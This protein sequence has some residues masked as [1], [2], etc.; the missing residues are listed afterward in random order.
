[1]GGSSFSVNDWAAKSANLRGKSLHQTNTASRLSDDINPA[2]MKGGKRE[3]CDSDANPNSTAI[4]IGLDMTGSMRG[5]LSHIMQYGLGDLFK[6]IYDRKPVSDPQVLF[7]GIGDAMVNDPAPFQIGQFESECGRLIDDLQKFW[8]D[9]CSGGGN[10]MESYDLPYYFAGHLT[11]TD[12]M[13][14]RNQKGFI[15]TIGDE[16]PPKVLTKEIIKNVFGL[17]VEKDMPFK[18]VL[19][20]ACQSYIPFHIIM[21]EGS[22]PSNYGL[23]CVLNPWR[24]LLGENAIVCSDHKKLSEVIVSILEVKAGKNKTAVENSW[25][26]STALVV[27]DAIKNLPA[28]TDEGM[29][30]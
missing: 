27:R 26:A 8:V 17:D 1:M 15:F 12:C 3:S 19:R 5:I 6:E 7:C 18:D 28:N 16:P 9:G 21:S 20:T 25:D 30:F 2:Q 14:K 24:D 23:D 10:D 4:I 13:L 22:H 11:K 29:V